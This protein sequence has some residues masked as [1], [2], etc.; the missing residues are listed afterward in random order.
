MEDTV[1]SSRM[2][3]NKPTFILASL[4]NG[5]DNH[6][7][8]PV[9][10]FHFTR[11]VMSAN[12]LASIHNAQV[13]FVDW[14]SKN[15]NKYR[16]HL[17]PGIKYVYVKPFINEELHKNNNSTMLFYEWIAKDIGAY[18]AETNWLL[19]TNGDNFFPTQTIEHLNQTQLNPNQWYSA[20]RLNIKNN[21]FVNDIAD[22]QQTIDTKQSQFD[23]IQECIFCHGDF[24]LCFKEKYEQAGGYDYIHRH[25]YGDH[26]LMN[27]LSQIGCNQ[28]FLNLHFYHISHS[29][30]GQAFVSSEASIDKPYIK[31]L[32]LSTC[33]VETIK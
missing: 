24:T 5:Y 12:S 8:D 14:C 10:N 16:S 11:T 13:I 1:N 6:E 9:K 27:K 30:W 15:E 31:Q 17:S 32:I 23:V 4:N 22:F 2:E 18:F 3:T 19:F 20:K 33:E 26:W 25:A 28:Q 21:V 7:S 29:A